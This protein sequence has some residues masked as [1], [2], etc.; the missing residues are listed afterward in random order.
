[1][2]MSEFVY[3]NSCINQA[4]E[5]AST[6]IHQEVI[7]YKRIKDMPLEELEHMEVDDD[8]ECSKQNN[9]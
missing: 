9:F 1:M 6:D 2:P 5:N 7:E 3:R 4:W 8:E